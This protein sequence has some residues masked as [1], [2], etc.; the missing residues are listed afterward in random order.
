MANSHFWHGDFLA[1]LGSALIGERELLALGKEVGWETLHAFTGQWFAYSEKRMA[2]AIGDIPKGAAS[3]QSTHDAIP[4][5]PDEGIQVTS[6]VSV[7][8]EAGRI[9]VDLLDNADQM[10]CGLNVSESCTRTA[11]YIGVFNS[12]DHTVPKNA[13]SLR[14]I[15]LKLKDDSVDLVDHHDRLDLLTESLS[16]NILSLHADTLDVIDDDKGTVGDTESGSDL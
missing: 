14:R 12:I 9:E 7:D 4:G 3:A 5:T 11:A 13:G 15:E 1:M 2:D 16:E 6:K 8:P 10:N